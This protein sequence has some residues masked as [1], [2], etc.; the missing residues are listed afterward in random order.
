LRPEKG[1]HWLSTNSISSTLS[2]AL[3]GQYPGNLTT[4]TTNLLLPSI[5]EST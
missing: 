2:A 3:L 5:S 1:F 4:K